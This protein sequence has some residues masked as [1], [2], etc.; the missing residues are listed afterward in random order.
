MQWITSLV[1]PGK[2]KD[3]ALELKDVPFKVQGYADFPKDGVVVLA[4]LKSVNDN[5]P[6]QH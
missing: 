4:K 5:Q 6:V 1:K 2:T 3:V